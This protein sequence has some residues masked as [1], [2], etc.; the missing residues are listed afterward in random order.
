MTDSSGVECRAVADDGAAIPGTFGSQATPSDGAAEPVT[1]VE[2][3]TTLWRTGLLR[4]GVEGVVS[5]EPGSDPNTAGPYPVPSLV[6][7][8]DQ[9]DGHSVVVVGTSPA[10]CASAGLAGLAR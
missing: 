2:F 9:A 8:V 1:P 3:C 6:A 4:P 5:P 10:A 7:C